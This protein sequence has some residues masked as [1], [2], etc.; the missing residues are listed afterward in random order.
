MR[1]LAVIAAALCAQPADAGETP[2]Q[3][4]APG[5][6]VRLISTGEVDASGGTLVGL[7]IDMPETTKTYWRVPGETGIPTRI[8]VSRSSGI[9]GHRVLWPYPTIDKQSGYLDYAYFGPTV[10][11][12]E[13]E[14][15][16]DT[17]YLDLSATLGVCEEICIPVEARFEM[18]LGGTAADHANSLRLR[19][20]MAMA[21]ITWDGTETP[22][23]NVRFDAEGNALVVEV[24]AGEVDPA[25]LIG[26]LPDGLPLLGAP[27]PHAAD[28]SVRLPVI[29]DGADL[30]SAMLAGQSVDLVFQTREGPFSLTRRI[31]P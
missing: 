27:Q 25:S 6:S 16:E 10:L 7:E 15:K 5:V 28:G 20:A 2:W 19:Q 12:I 14:L 17:A 21:P 8:D 31:D 23:G 11:P 4:V 26:A 29:G 13:L 22:V 18:P 9:T 24:T 30:T 1:T 3:E